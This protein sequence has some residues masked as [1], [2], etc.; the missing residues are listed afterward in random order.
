MLVEIDEVEV[1]AADW[2]AM[3]KGDVAAK[4]RIQNAIDGLY[5]YMHAL[6]SEGGVIVT[7]R[8][9]EKHNV[10]EGVKIDVGMYR[11]KPPATT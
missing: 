2:A 7:L 6:H 5:I 1:N 8:D 11:V 10:I 4:A 9:L 3:L